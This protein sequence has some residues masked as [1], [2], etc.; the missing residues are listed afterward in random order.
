MQRIGV[1]E[2]R[3]NA[4]RYLA[5]VAS[6]EIVEVTQRGRLVARIVPAGGDAWADLVAAGEVIAASS[7]ENLLSEPPGKFGS[8]LSAELERLREDER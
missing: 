8:G 4:S 7:N 3:Q 5:L 6:G 2:L 1:R